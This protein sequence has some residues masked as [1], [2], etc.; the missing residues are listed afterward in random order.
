MSLS[1]PAWYELGLRI[2]ALF[3][4]LGVILTVVDAPHGKFNVANSRV[5]NIWSSP[6]FNTFWSSPVLNVNGQLAWIVME[7]PSP[8]LLIGS[9]RISHT[10]LNLGLKSPM[11]SEP[12]VLILLM[13][14]VGH[15]INRAV[16]SP[17]R[18]T[19]RSPSH[20]IVPLS[21]ILFN[22]INAS[23][24]GTFFAYLSNSLS[25]TRL[26]GMDPPNCLISLPKNGQFWTGIIM[27]VLG[28]VSNVGHDEILLRLRK[29]PDSST[30][31]ATINVSKKERENRKDLQGPKYLIPYGGLYRFIS[32]PNYLSEWFEWLGF[33]IASSSLL[34]LVRCNNADISANLGL[35]PKGWYTPPWMFLVAEVGVMLPRAVR[36]HAWYRE[37]FGGRYPIERKAVIPGLL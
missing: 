10:R 31:S 29:S 37:R 28:F 36:G 25:A 20:I 19:S 32:Y 33:A 9:Y 27:F 34:S 14:Y 23:L 6:L 3:P 5:K 35:G 7:I 15:Y 17:L 30:P 24:M 1:P 4:A 12:A 26:M 16:I 21:A 8:L 11:S 22:T 2:Y 13:L 18:T